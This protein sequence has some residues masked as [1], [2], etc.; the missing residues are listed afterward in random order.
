MIVFN[1]EDQCSEIKEILQ[2]LGYE[3]VVETDSGYS[4]FKLYQKY[5]PEFVFMGILTPFCGEPSD[6]EYIIDEADAVKKI[7]QEFPCVKIFIIA[8]DSQRDKVICAIANGAL[9]YLL[10]PINLKSLEELINKGRG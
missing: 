3:V 6:V 2:T 10:K 4:A 8:L 9:N 5:Q 1:S 7:T